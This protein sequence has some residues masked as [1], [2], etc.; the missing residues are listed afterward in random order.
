MS[1]SMKIWLIV[2]TS[3]ILVGGIIFGG[4]MMALNW[5]FSKISKHAAYLNIPYLVW[6]TFAAYLNAAIWW[7]NR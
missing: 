7:L 4:I 3:L 5:D 6:L 1:K 2:A